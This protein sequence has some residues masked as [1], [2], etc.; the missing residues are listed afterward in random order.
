[1]ELLQRWNTGIRRDS[2]R[3]KWMIRWNFSWN[4]LETLP[5]P[6]N[7]H[8][9]GTWPLLQV[10]PEG[11]SSQSVLWVANAWTAADL[12][13]ANALLTA[14]NRCDIYQTFQGCIVWS[15]S[16]MCLSAPSQVMWL[17][18][19][20]CNGCLCWGK[21]KNKSCVSLRKLLKMDF[22]LFKG[23]TSCFLQFF[24]ARMC[25]STLSEGLQERKQGASKMS[26]CMGIVDPKCHQNESTIQ[27]NKMISN[28]F[29]WSDMY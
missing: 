13:T 20:P 26:K 21:I 22:R 3:L 29:K 5:S 8:V 9:A 14:Q 4:Y 1:M 7:A 16:G 23:C 19:P 18:G 25:L 11:S 6:C 28:E 15:F 10:W 27:L 24:Q 12:S 17:I 2:S